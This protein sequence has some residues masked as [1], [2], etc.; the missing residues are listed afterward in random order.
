MDKKEIQEFIKNE[1]SPLLIGIRND[2][3][4]QT[5]SN[6]DTDIETITIKAE[7][8]YT[9]LPDVDYPSK[10]TIFN[11]I[12]ENLPKKG[13]EYFT[14]S[15]IKEIVK[16]VLVLIPKP[17]NGLNGEKGKDGVVDYSIIKDVT[18]PII[19]GKYKELNTHI[20]GVS[21]ELLSKIAESK[22]PELTPT[23]IRNKLESLTGN[24]RLDAK[25]IKGLE[26]F[27]GTFI[28]TSSG[29]GG[30]GGTGGSQNLQQVTDIGAYTSLTIEAGGFKSQYIYNSL[31][32]VV[33]N[34]DTRKLFNTSSIAT[35][36]FENTQL[37][38]NTNS[39]TVDW[40]NYM[41]YAVG[42][43]P[44]LDWN[45]L[46]LK[47]YN[48]HFEQDMYSDGSVYSSD[49]IG[50]YDPTNAGYAY[51]N[52]DD[53]TFYLYDIDDNP[54]YLYCSSIYSTGAISATG[55]GVSG[56]ATAQYFK[57]SINGTASNP[58]FSRTTDFNTGMYFVAA[59]T[60]GFST[61]SNKRLEISTTTIT[62]SLPLTISAQNI[63]T[64][65]TTGTKIGTGTTQKLGFFNATPV[66][67]PSATTDIGVVLSNLGLRAVGTSFPITTSGAIN[68]NA[69]LT[70]AGASLT[71]TDVDVAL[72][73]T[74]GTKIGTGTT[75]KLGFYNATPIVQGASV[76]DATGGA[77]IDAEARTAINTLIS[78]IEAL[79]LIA[80]I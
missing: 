79:G 26:K 24:D 14:D 28:A 80:T 15:D 72:G 73:T 51:I 16:E 36:D 17:K 35:I 46:L 49:R 40:N 7:D 8:G 59:D 60:L 62:A 23:K 3:E 68:F 25:A 52:H 6:G 31:D 10:K 47:G 39:P 54:A 43:T 57:T 29:G 33:F 71:L 44:A 74:T 63:V 12:K 20:N 38:N 53:Y 48:W 11:F 37:I 70:V 69:G 21:K 9:P 75:Q 78:R 4:S 45:N 67:Q 55:I 77:T 18:T 19:E 34:T 76:A 61:N 32:D 30:G 27:M 42:F 56:E 2:I 22:T 5:E 58:V 50:I 66:V 64:D 65:T 13:K 1:I 41:L